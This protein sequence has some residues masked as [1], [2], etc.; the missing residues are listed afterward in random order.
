M[1]VQTVKMYQ[2]V[3]RMFC[4]EPTLHIELF[5]FELREY[6]PS[7]GYYRI[8]QTQYEAVRDKSRVQLRKVTMFE[9][10]LRMFSIGSVMYEELPLRAL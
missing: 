10:I 5:M 6:P 7:K 2:A 1:L 9:A 8:G 3:L 4:I